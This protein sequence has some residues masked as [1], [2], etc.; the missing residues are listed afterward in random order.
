MWSLCQCIPVSVCPCGPGGG[1][2]KGGKGGGGG[3]GKGGFGATVEQVFL[4][5]H[6]SNSRCR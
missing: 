5:G 2:G 3:G 4:T 1:G 6:A